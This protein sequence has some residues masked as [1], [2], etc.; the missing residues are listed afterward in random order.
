MDLKDSCGPIVT[1]GV[2]LGTSTLDRTLKKSKKIPRLMRYCK[3]VNGSIIQN[4]CRKCTRDIVLHFTRL[5]RLAK[6]KLEN[7]SKNGYSLQGT[8][9]YK[10]QMQ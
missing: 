5:S 6:K 3:G 1:K 10:K 9:K 7:R 2:F 4:M 8:E